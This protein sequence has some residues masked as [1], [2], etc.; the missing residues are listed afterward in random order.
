[1]MPTDADNFLAQ[2]IFGTLGMGV[3]MYGKIKPCLKIL[4]VGLVMS[5][6]TFIVTETWMI[7]TIGIG[8]FVVLAKIKD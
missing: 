5:V 3:F 8:L 4:L 2:M 6:Y 1:M 7:W